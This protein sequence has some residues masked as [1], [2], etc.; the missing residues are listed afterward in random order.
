MQALSA[1]EVGDFALLPLIDTSP[2]T[3]KVS[4][5]GDAEASVALERFLAQLNDAVVASGGGAV[6]LDLSDLYFMN[7]ACIRVLAS[8]VHGV[9]AAGN[10]YQVH[11]HMNPQQPW[12]RRSLQPIKRLAPLV[13]RLEPESPGGSTR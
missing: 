8:W 13:V 3:V 7:S 4:G 10:L 2:P 12:Q 5:N 6:R 9:K 11:I 1:I